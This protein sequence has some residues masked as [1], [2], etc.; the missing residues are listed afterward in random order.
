M[1]GQPDNDEPHQET[2]HLLRGPENARR[3]ISAIQRL[4]SGGGVEH[5]LVGQSQ[6]GTTTSGDRPGIAGSSGGATR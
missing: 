1:I 5:D 2:A 4:E 6:P 3:L